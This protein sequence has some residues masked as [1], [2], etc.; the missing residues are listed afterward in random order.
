VRNDDPEE[1]KLVADVLEL[2]G[3]R[4]SIGGVRSKTTVMM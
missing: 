1:S 4:A 2:K 3:D